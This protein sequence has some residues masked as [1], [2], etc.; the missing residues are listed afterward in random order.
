MPVATHDSAL[1]CQATLVPTGDLAR[2]ASTA[3]ARSLTSKLV[4]VV[5]FGSRARGDASEGSDWDLLVIAEDLPARLLDRQLYLKGILPPHC[6]GSVSILAKTPRQFEAAVS[7]LYLDI[8]LDGRVLYD[9]RG[10]AAERLA[11]LRRLMERLGL[12]RVRTPEGYDWRWNHAPSG[13]WILSWGD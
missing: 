7:S 10:Y 3:L 8:A 5:L 11:M 2:E 12:R 4:A 6:R 9:P 1:D 13:G